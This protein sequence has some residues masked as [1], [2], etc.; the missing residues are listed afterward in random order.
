MIVS[1]E[2]SYVQLKYVCIYIL[3]KSLNLYAVVDKI[4]FSTQANIY[5][6]SLHRQ[7]E[8]RCFVRVNGIRKATTL[9]YILICLH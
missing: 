5:I 1:F 2:I 9:F 7:F 6:F 3:I 8:L 4:M